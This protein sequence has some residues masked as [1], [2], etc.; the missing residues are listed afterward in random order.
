[1]DP[2]I[3]VAVGAKT[4]A[5]ILALAL[6]LIGATLTWGQSRPPVTALP[7]L[8][9]VAE[10]KRLTPEQAALGYPV[11]LRA[12]VIFHNQHR[13]CF[14]RDD[15]DGVFLA[16]KQARTFLEAG[17]LVEIEGVTAPGD[18]AP[19]LQEHQV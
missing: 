5:T 16:R 15:T 2:H 10:I 1:M 8:T 14:I 11:C 6:P 4:G 3:P 13:D 17:Q 12:T 18:F 7:L 19:V 9:S